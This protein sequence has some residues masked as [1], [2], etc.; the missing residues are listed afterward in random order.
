MNTR[1]KQIIDFIRKL[2]GTDGPIPLHAPVFIGNEKKYLAECVDSTFVSYVGPFVERFEREIAA[3]TGSKYAV[4]TVNGTAG[5]HV[6][7]ILAG[8][9]PGDE[10]ITQAVSFIAT[11]NA[12]RYCGADPVFIDSSMETLGMSPASLQEFL[13]EHGLMK[14][15]GHCYNKKTGRR[16]A[17]CVPMHVFGHPVEIEEIIGVCDKSS[18]PVVEDAAES[19]GSR[20]KSRHTGTFGLMGVL[21]FNGN[22]TLTTGGGGM[23]L[24]D[25]ETL[26]KKAK[27]L[28]TT[29]KVPH[30]FE[31]VHDE[32]GYNYRMPNVNA[33]LGCAQLEC[34][35]EFLES[36]RRIA[37]EYA[38]FFGKMGIPF[39]GEKPDYVS[40][41]W[42]NS[43]FLEDVAEKEAFLRFAVENKIMARPLWKLINHQPQFKSCRHGLLKN[44][45]NIENRLVNLPS[46]PVFQ[47]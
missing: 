36:K 12:I 40:N 1:F 41:Y 14:E 39:F 8:V 42:L 13:S 45:E 24:T 30:P 19:I 31:F 5:L 10:V 7:L 16:F 4:A 18:I 35:A 11:A 37:G 28:T 15:D 27:H 20:Y 29:A 33:A 21:S 26:A 44:A 17:A 2:Y 9:R 43:I 22:K 34:L 32:V 38:A 6:A 23:I 25:N 47:R 46:S 3:Y